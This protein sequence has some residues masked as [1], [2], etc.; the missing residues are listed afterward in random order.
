MAGDVTIYFIQS[1]KDGPVKI[2]KTRNVQRRMNE[3]Q[4][5]SFHEL[6]LLHYFKADAFIEGAFHEALADHRIRG[7]WF[8]AEP[9]LEILREITPLGFDDIIHLIAQRI[10]ARDEAFHEKR[11]ADYAEANPPLNIL[12]RKR[13]A[14]P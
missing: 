1:G 11:L 2:G 14:K 10:T 9:A 5:A 3:L 12:T 13:K 4:V 8:A 6:H 7:E